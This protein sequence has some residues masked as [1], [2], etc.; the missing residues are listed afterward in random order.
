MKLAALRFAIPVAA[1]ALLTACVTPPPRT[2]AVPAPPPPRV[3]V[4]PAH[5]QSPEQTDRDRYECHVW[6]VQQSG[7]DPSRSDANAY[8]RVIVQPANPPGSATAAGAI[9]G[10]IL[11]AIIAGPRNAGAGL[12]LGGATGAVIGSA[13]DADAQAQAQQM[14]QQYNQSTAAGRARA[15]TYR[16]AIG[17]C[18]V[19]RGYSIS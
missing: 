14:Q 4:Y 15:S 19:G 17:A 18:L 11:G 16:R 12:V 2:Y 9:G 6:A 10:A 1:V 8:E 3:F 5:G 7:V 13:S